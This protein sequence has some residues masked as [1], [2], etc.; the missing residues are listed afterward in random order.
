MRKLSASALATFLKSPR[1]FYYRHVA[2][3]EPVM[4]SVATWDHDKIAGSL[5]SAFV[6]RFYK[7]TGERENVAKMLS[8]WEEQTASWV[9]EKVKERLTKALLAWGAA[10]YQQFSPSD[11]CR[12][13]EGSEL[14]IENERFVGYLDG[15][16]ADG[17]IHEVKS[18][19]RSPQLSEQLL[20]VQSS[21]QIKLYAV[22]TDATG[23][24]IEFAWKDSP[25]QIFRAPALAI[26]AQQ[27]AHWK[28]ELDSLADSIYALGDDE[29]NY[30]CHTDCQIMTKNFS[31]SCP[32]QALCLGLEGAGIAY[33]TREHRK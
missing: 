6:D 33:K 15:I 31:G 18:T 1:L 5:W 7:G 27:R 14:K 11:G 12:T 29:H 28:Q 3:L 13:A 26:T 25:Y 23:V 30:V 22:M 32:Y 8:D 17:I 20:K 21:I 9:P 19:S 4:L 10:Y 24:V 2:N 16:S